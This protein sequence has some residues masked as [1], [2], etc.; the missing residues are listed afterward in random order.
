[1]V[2]GSV[3]VAP[4]DG[5]TGL[6]QAIAGYNK[7]TLRTGLPQD[8]TGRALNSTYY[9]A[10]LSHACEAAGNLSEARIH[11]EAAINAADETGECWFEPELHRLKG[12]LLL[13]QYPDEEAQAEASFRLA[14]ER[15]A[16]RNALFWELRGSLSL[17][18]LLVA[19][20]RPD[21]ARLTLA[22]VYHMFTEGLDWPDLC[23]AKTLLGSLPR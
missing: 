10:L 9:R 19:L 20:D 6:A 22:P 16:R 4:D 15:A 21:Q 1:M 3:F 18:Q 2:L 14:V 8:D 13:R 12:E 17:A 11:I 5:A 23:E 7:Y